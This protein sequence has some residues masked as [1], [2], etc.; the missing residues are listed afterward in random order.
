MPPAAPSWRASPPCNNGNFGLP[1]ALF[2]LGQPGLD[3]AVVIFLCSVVLTFTLGPLLYGSAG[4][5]RA[6]LLAVARLPVVWCI[7]AALLVRL[8]HV[9]VPLGLRRGIDLLGQAALPMVLLSLGIQLGQAGRLSLTGP[10]FTAVSLRGLG[11]QGLVLASAMPTA[12]NAFLLAREYGADS[13][14]VASAVA[15]STLASL[16]TAALV[17]ALLPRIGELG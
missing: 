15:L 8:L 6:G 10:V 1:V 7:A 4:G 12:V 16:L 9:P 5:A 17:V 11:L 3:Q 14:T 13:E 2:A